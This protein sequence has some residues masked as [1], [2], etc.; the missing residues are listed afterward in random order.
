MVFLA[1]FIR[2][3]KRVDIL[4]CFHLLLK[5]QWNIKRKLWKS[6]LIR[7]RDSGNLF[8]MLGKYCIEEST[9]RGNL[10][11]CAEVQSMTD[12]IRFIVRGTRGRVL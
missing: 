7:F 1:A 11:A 8:F 5:K 6:I 9:L 3:G 4:T 2:A 12:V 10:P